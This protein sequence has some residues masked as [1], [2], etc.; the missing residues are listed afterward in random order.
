MGVH[1]TWI[2]CTSGGNA[3]TIV[4]ALR[5]PEWDHTTHRCLEELLSPSIW[6]NQKRTSVGA[7]GMASMGARSTRKAGI[8]GS[9]LRINEE[10]VHN[11]NA[12][13]TCT[14]RGFPFEA[15]SVVS[16]ASVSRHVDAMNDPHSSV[17][18]VAFGEGRIWIQ[19]FTGVEVDG[20]HTRGPLLGMVLPLERGPIVFGADKAHSS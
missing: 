6:P 3:V 16:H 18:L 11:V 1:R 20:S 19:R 9:T 17:L 14:L 12:L 10:V 5:L 7:T 2:C 13:L 15:W 4:P 8:T